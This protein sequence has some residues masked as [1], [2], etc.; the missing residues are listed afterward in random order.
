MRSTVAK[1]VLQNL[2]ILLNLKSHWHRQAKI[3]D[4]THHN[5]DKNSPSSSI[6]GAILS[7]NPTKKKLSMISDSATTATANLALLDCSKSLL[8][9]LFELSSECSRC[10]LQPPTRR[11]LC[12]LLLPPAPSTITKLFFLLFFFLLLFLLG[13]ASGSRGGVVISLGNSSSLVN[14]NGPLV[15]PPPSKYWFSY[16]LLRQLELWL[17]AEHRDWDGHGMCRWQVSVM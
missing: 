14:H 16:W 10:L 9:L 2:T 6:I 5:R 13:T 15:Q 7:V 11:H 17:L 8:P 4:C 12:V 1:I 3:H